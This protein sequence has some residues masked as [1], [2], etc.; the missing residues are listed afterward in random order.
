LTI[1]VECECT[2]RFEVPDS[3]AGGLA[4]CPGCRRATPV[5]GLRD[6]AWRAIQAA[7]VAGAVVVAVVVGRAAGPVAGAAAFFAVLA[8]LW[9]LSRAL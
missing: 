9:L 2:R 5:P 6:P 1:S 3:L 7:A 8:V 4:S